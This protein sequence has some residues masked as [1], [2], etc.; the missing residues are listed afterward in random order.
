M[1]NNQIQ[2]AQFGTILKKIWN[3]LG[4]AAQ[5]AQIA[6]APSVMT[7]SGWRVD[8]NGKAVQDQQNNPAVEQLRDNLATIGEAAIAA[9]TAVKDVE[10]AYQAVRHPIQTARAVKT[11][12]T[13]AA[14]ATKQLVAKGKN[15][16]QRFKESRNFNPIISNNNRKVI[17]L[18]QNNL[19]KSTKD[20][21]QEALDNVIIDTNKYHSSEDYLQRIIN[22]GLFK[23][24]EIP[25]FLK[26]YEKAGRDIRFQISNEFSDWEGKTKTIKY[27]I[28]KKVEQ[29][30]TIYEQPLEGKASHYIQE[31]V[32]H[33]AGGHGFTLAYNPTKRRHRIFMENNYPL[34]KRALDYN[35]SIMPKLN[36]ETELFLKTY[37]QP[38]EKILKENPS[39]NRELLQHNKNKVDFINY[40]K[41]FQETNARGHQVNMS[42]FRGGP[43]ANESDGYQELSGI[44]EDKS[45]QNFLEKKLS[46]ILPFLG[47][48]YL[49]NQK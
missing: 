28:D 26:E 2:K 38:L 37:S 48:A 7:A 23:E 6:E 25:Q 21:I 44:Y 18:V 42:K 45:L 17:D 9:P 27:P 3:T 49:S 5:V 29:I 32:D 24:E 1:K 33:E 14:Q 12:A 31:V 13:Q 40:M 36:Q 20:K 22:S 47:T 11:A 30:V 19:N 10:L 43:L 16:V 4:N 34:L 41:D 8:R 35:Y 39:L 46:L 15:A